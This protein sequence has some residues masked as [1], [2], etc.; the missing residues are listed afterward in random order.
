MV[1]F[2]KEVMRDEVLHRILKIRDESHPV[3]KLDQK[4]L[5]INRRPSA[6]DFLLH[7]TFRCLALLTFDRF[8]HVIVHK[9]D[10]P[11]I[12]LLKPELKVFVYKLKYVRHLMSAHFRSF[13]QVDV[14]DIPTQIKLPT[15]ID[16]F[17]EAV[18]RLITFD[19]N[20]LK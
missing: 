18:N 12:L 20:W 4:R 7:L 13:E 17:A 19:H 5:R 10:L 8:D 6:L 16:F 14:L 2:V 1:R 11:Q 3:V 9:I 15:S